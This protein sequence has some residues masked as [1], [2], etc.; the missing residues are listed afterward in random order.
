MLKSFSA[1]PKALLRLAALAIVAV[2]IGCSAEPP[3]MVREDFP[4]KL[5]TRVRINTQKAQEVDRWAYYKGDVKTLEQIQYADGTTTYVFFREDLTASRIMELHPAMKGE[6]KRRLKVEVNFEAD[7]LAYADH[8]VVRPDGTLHKL[9]QRR[10]DRSYLTTTYF[11]DGVTTQRVAIYKLDKSLLS[12]TEVD[13]DGTKLLETVT[14]SSGYLTSRHFRR[15]GTLWMSYKRPPWN[16]GSVDGSY[17]E[18]DGVTPKADFSITAW[19]KSMTFRNHQGKRLEIGFENYGVKRMS[20]TVYDFASGN[21]LYQQVYLHVAD[22]QFDL[23]G[24]FVLAAVEQYEGT[25]NR[26]QKKLKRRFVIGQD[27]KTITK[28]FVPNSQWYDYNGV[29][30]TLYPSGFISSK[31]SVGWNVQ[32]DKQDFPDGTFQD[33]VTVLDLP[34]MLLAPSVEKLPFPDVKVPDVYWY[35][36]P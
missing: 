1:W 29:E 13:R 18:A 5:S 21:P 34:E 23:T 20:V 35:W 33:P 15:D 32:P 4:Q 7:G 22:S 27:G 36:G 26:Y 25:G 9:G 16:Y 28:V 12:E 2:L 24:K 14:D 31:Q 10:E 6:E 8:K 17:F 11:E 19:Q 30:Y 3:N